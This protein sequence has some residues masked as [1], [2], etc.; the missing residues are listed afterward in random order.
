MTLKLSGA[1]DV[2]P[3]GCCV[4]ETDEELLQTSFPAYRRLSIFIRLPERGDSTELAPI[5]DIDPAE[6]AASAARR[7]QKRL[8][9]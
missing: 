9:P 5:I 4:V 6:L 2:Q 1:D 7:H 3:A 8:T